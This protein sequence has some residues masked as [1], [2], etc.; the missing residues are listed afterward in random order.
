MFKTCHNKL[1]H[2]G[3]LEILRNLKKESI[4]LHNMLNS[5]MTYSYHVETSALICSANQW[6]GFYIIGTSLMK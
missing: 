2:P 4:T 1:L 3:L 6:T 5:F